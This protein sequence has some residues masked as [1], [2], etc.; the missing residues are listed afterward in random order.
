VEKA[1]ERLSGAPA[2]RDDFDPPPHADNADADAA[3]SPGKPV[4]PPADDRPPD[5]SEPAAVDLDDEDEPYEDESY[6]DDDGD[7]VAPA[8]PAR[9]GRLRRLLTF[10]RKAGEAATSGAGGGLVRMM[11]ARRARSAAK[12]A[13]MAEGRLPRRDEAS[14]DR[15]AHGDMP[16]PARRRAAEPP[17]ATTGS[18]G[19]SGRR[20]Y[21]DDSLRR[22]RQVAIDQDAMRANGMLTLD[23]ERSVIAEE[24]RLVKRPLL[25]KAFAEGDEKIR[26]G[27]LI[28]VS[29]GRPGEGKTF[30]AVNLAMSIA[31]ERD[32]TVML[33]DADV[34]KPSVPSTLGFE[35]ELGLIDLIADNGL[36]VSDVLVRTDI[37][38]LT[39]LPAGRPHHLATELLASER[40]EQLI[41]ELAE[42]YPDRVIIIDSSPVL[43]SSV[44]GVLALY[45]GQIVFVVQAEKSTQTSIDAGLG[46]ISACEN[47]YLLLNKT[48][49]IGGS[50][51]FGAYYG[52][53]R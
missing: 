22:T 23:A 9:P 34:A 21:R 36:D 41:V 39:V 52:Y 49:S 45:V 30:C 12:K 26:H 29:S 15:A 8:A 48:R 31:L 10:G 42:R 4:P 14:A 18:A 19:N 38:N 5:A 33:I 25:L 16:R 27:N 53:Y 11:A 6:G 32:L 3:A 13:A 43:M 51:K 1:A 7:T 17:Q 47:I 44:P 2:D 40:M 24:F 37:E 35:A 46:L 20:P 50:E 28:M